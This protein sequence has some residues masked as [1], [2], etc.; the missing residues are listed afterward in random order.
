MTETRSDVDLDMEE[1]IRRWHAGL[2][3]EIAKM[4]EE[5]VEA[6]TLTLSRVFIE[7][8]GK[9]VEKAGRGGPETPEQQEAEF[10]K[11]DHMRHHFP[12]QLDFEY[13]VMLPLPEAEKL[14]MIANIRSAGDVAT[15]VPIHT[16][17]PKRKTRETQ[18]R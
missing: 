10:H 1:R 15:D 3:T 12:S 6:K 5:N 17:E 8:E 14:V 4:R 11:W 9:A 2:P 18:P 16:Q 13:W 7:D